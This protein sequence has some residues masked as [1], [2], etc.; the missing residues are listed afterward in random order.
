MVFK[1]AGSKFWRYRLDFNGVEINKS[2]K[3]TNKE[4]ARQMESAHR[5]R[6]AKG[7]VGLVEKP[8]APTL[9]QFADRFLKHVRDSKADKPATVVFYERRTKSL[10]EDKTLSQLPLDAITSENISAYAGRMRKRNYEVATIN[11]NLATLRRMTK[12]LAEWDDIPCRKV[13]LLDGENG[14]DR[15]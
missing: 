12:L 5:T 9:A 6:L 4:V 3:Q 14:R 10:L 8:S 15:V 7:E 13:T 2:T 11:R 1:K